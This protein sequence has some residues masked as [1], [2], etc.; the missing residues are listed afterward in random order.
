M[1]PENDD[2]ED[3]D[4]APKRLVSNVR[5]E[6]NFPYNYDFAFEE[7][8]EIEVRL[9]EFDYAIVVLEEELKVEK[10]NLSILK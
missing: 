10:P 4:F 8:D 7:L 1:N 6:F 2:D 3:V 9:Q 5:T